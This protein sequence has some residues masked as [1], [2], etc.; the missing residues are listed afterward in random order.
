MTIVNGG[1]VREFNWVSDQDNGIDPDPAR[2]DAEFDGVADAIN[3]IV[4]GTLPFLNFVSSV[5]GTTASP[6]FK[7]A[8][9]PNS[10]FRRRADGAIVMVIDGVDVLT[11]TPNDVTHMGAPVATEASLFGGPYTDIPLAEANADVET[12]VV[13]LARVN[14]VP[15]FSSVN[16]NDRLGIGALFTAA[17]EFTF[18]GVAPSE[19]I[20]V[21]MGGTLPIVHT[22]VGGTFSFTLRGSAPDQLVHLG[23][24]EVLA[25]ANKE[26]V[27]VILEA[28]SV[29]LYPN[30]NYVFSM[31]FSPGADPGGNTTIGIGYSSGSLTHRLWMRRVSPLDG[32]A[33]QLLEGILAEPLSASGPPGLALIEKTNQSDILNL[34]GSVRWAIPA[35]WHALI[36]EG[37]AVVEV[38]AQVV[39]DLLPDALPG[40]TRPD[41][42][43]AS[44]VQFVDALDRN[45]D[46]ITVHRTSEFLPTISP[47]SHFD[48]S[49]AYKSSLQIPPTTRGF[50]IPGFDG[51][52]ITFPINRPDGI[53]FVGGKSAISCSVRGVRIFFG[54]PRSSG[55]NILE[56][57]VLRSLM[58]ELCL[59]RALDI[60]SRDKMVLSG[61]DGTGDSL[62]VSTVDQI[63][64][65]GI[66][67]ST[68]IVPSTAVDAT[69]AQLAAAS[70][71]VAVIGNDNNAYRVLMSALLGGG[72]PGMGVDLQ[73]VL[74]AILVDGTV[75]D[76]LQILADRSVAGRITIMLGREGAMYNRY[77]L[78]SASAN[79]PTATE[80][81]AGTS[82]MTNRATLP[83]GG[84]HLW[85]A[86]RYDD[87]ATIRQI[88]NENWREF[89]TL[90]PTS[91]GD[92]G[93]EEYFAYG[94]TFSLDDFDAETTWEA[95]R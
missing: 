18:R 4:R 83:I 94:L 55:V 67:H 46:P 6:G 69:A 90:Q 34:D 3:A 23:T 17:H 79:A 64:A 37:K 81:Q 54:V 16:V 84:G 93:G 77:W 1:Y 44:V 21:E 59:K 78:W 42:T 14:F 91:L 73:T 72:V 66:R 8:Q 68:E 24:F 33:L 25:R 31:E 74:D 29:K 63:V 87:I 20:D 15:L 28:N 52:A 56:A 51:R 49:V 36:D 70:G 41:G 30:S 7:F 47:G 35:S 60:E 19:S 50:A 80:F 95:L 43:L 38:S 48:Q 82:S 27:N 85:L 65:A 39:D 9:S 92:I 62:Y 58:E 22:G 10:G 89:F 61:E 76:G 40:Y 45:V 26:T 53:D 5:D 2:F 11:V 71:Q 32:R 57:G 13:S 88:G 12:A 86:E 75:V